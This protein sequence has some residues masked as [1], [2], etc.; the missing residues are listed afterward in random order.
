MCLERTV[1]ELKC[2]AYQLV[3]CWFRL[4]STW[5][6]WLLHASSS[7]LSNPPFWCFVLYLTSCHSSIKFHRNWVK[8]PTETTTLK[9]IKIQSAKRKPTNNNRRCYL[10]DAGDLIT[11][12]K[13]NSLGRHCEGGAWR[14]CGTYCCHHPLAYSTRNCFQSQCAN[15]PADNNNGTKLRHSY[16]FCVSVLWRWKKCSIEDRR[17]VRYVFIITLR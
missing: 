8:I 7:M 11:A 2:F 14:W 4:C 3:F 6:I 10:R 1:E 15:A 17:E 12:I 13:C 16:L 5:F 9:K